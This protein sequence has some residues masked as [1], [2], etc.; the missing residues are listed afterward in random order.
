MSLA[1]KKNRY[2]ILLAS[3]LFWNNLGTFLFFALLIYGFV[4]FLS[5]VLGAGIAAAV[6]RIRYSTWDVALLRF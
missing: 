4:Y 5:F 3:G 6:N 2:V 1:I